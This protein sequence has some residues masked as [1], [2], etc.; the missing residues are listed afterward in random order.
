MAQIL[1]YPFQLTGAGTVATVEEGTDGQLAQ[2]LAVAVL[3]S[4]DERPLLNDYGIADPAFRGFDTEA[5][6]LHVELHG[7]PVNI[8]DVAIVYLDDNTQD[9]V[10]TFT[11]S[12]E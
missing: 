10:V 1:A 9:V 7:P 12:D 4:P 2:E 11:S 6:R 8:E 5:L 3:T